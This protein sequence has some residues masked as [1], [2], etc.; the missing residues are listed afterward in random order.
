MALP[1]MDERHFVL[2]RG[3]VIVRNTNGRTELNLTRP[4]ERFCRGKFGSTACQPVCLTACYHRT[5]VT[6]GNS[7]YIGA[8]AGSF[9]LFHLW[10]LALPSHY[11]RQRANEATEKD[12]WPRN[13]ESRLGEQ[14]NVILFCL[15]FAFS[16]SSLFVSRRRRRAAISCSRKLCRGNTSAHWSAAAGDEEAGASAS[17]RALG[18]LACPCRSEADDAFRRART[19]TLLLCGERERWRLR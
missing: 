9:V 3:A 1:G 7:R 11:R 16:F 14:W 4:R 2:V 17:A 6:P 8:C 13:K 15:L 10:R 12:G 19:R 5:G 18:W